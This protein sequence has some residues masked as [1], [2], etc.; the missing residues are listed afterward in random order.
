MLKKSSVVLPSW[1]ELDDVVDVTDKG[2]VI[3]V[4]YKLHAQGCGNLTMTFCRQCSK[5]VDP[6]GK[7]NYC[8]YCGSKLQ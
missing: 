6:F 2:T 1:I 8:P 3:E 5:Q 7:W 4:S